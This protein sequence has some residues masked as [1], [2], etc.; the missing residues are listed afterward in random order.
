MTHP[1][2][3]ALTTLLERVEVGTLCSADILTDDECKL[4]YACFPAEIEGVGASE[5]VSLAMDGDLN[6]A[7]A[8][9]AATCPGEHQVTVDWGPSGCGTKLVWWPDGLSDG[10]HIASEG[11][12]VDP[13]RAMLGAVIRAM[14]AA[15]ET[16][17][18]Q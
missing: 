4:I 15:A 17:D 5:W 2:T 7:E 9:I 14:I 18:C 16:E 11:Y 3:A 10:R 12:D 13:A 1:Q 6:A 8:L